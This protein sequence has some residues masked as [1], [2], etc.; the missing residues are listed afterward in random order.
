MKA[1]IPAETGIW[2]SWN[3]MGRG[4]PKSVIPAKAGTQCLCVKAEWIPAFAG[5]TTGN[6]LSRGSLKALDPRLRGDDDPEG[7]CCPAIPKDMLRQNRQLALR[8]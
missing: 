2:S 5:M 8:V 3:A 1:V 4:H 6:D 7:G